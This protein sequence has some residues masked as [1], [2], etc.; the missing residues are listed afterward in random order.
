RA[1][2]LDQPGSI[3][4]LGSEALGEVSPYTLEPLGI[5]YPRA[6][7][8]ALYAAAQRA[9]PSWAQATPGL[10]GRRSA[11]AGQSALS[12]AACAGSRYSS[13]RVITPSLMVTMQ[14]A[15]MR[16]GLPSGSVA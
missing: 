8:D 13:R 11:S 5:D 4:R 16:N 2:D 15:S 3:G 14:Q 1:S 12:G 9:M 6:D 10:S 7:P